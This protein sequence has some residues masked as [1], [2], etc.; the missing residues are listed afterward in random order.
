MTNS[1]LTYGTRTSVSGPIMYWFVK[2]IECPFCVGQRIVVDRNRGCSDDEIKSRMEF[3]RDYFL[4]FYDICSSASHFDQPDELYKLD[5][6]HIQSI[7]KLLIT[8][9]NLT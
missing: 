5:L 7:I 9:M 1:E 3:A 6:L 2:S 8:R 4:Y